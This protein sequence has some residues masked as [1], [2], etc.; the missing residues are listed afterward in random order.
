MN[1]VTQGCN[2]NDERENRLDGR[3]LLHFSAT[4]I[5]D[6]KHNL[7]SNGLWYT[8]E[9]VLKHLNSLASADGLHSSPSSAIHDLF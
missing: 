8:T 3:K 2:V 6:A 1:D 9:Q 5:A 7:A 4:E